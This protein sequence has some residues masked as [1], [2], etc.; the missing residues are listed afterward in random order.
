M[1][2]DHGHKIKTEFYNSILLD[3]RYIL[4][5]SGSGPNSIRFWEALGAGAIPVLLADTL[6]LP[7]HELWEKSIVRIKECELE[8]IDDILGEINEEEER[9][10]RENCLKLYEYFR[11]NYKNII[12]D[13]IALDIHVNYI[14][15]YYNVFGH[16]Y[17]DHLFILYKIKCWLEETKNIKIK[18]IYVPNQ[19]K[20]AS[21]IIPFYEMLFEKVLV[22]PVDNM[23]QL[24]TIIGSI[25]GTETN[26]IY[27]DRSEIPFNIPNDVMTNGRKLTDLNRKR[28]KELREIIWKHCD[29]QT[30]DRKSSKEILIVDRKQSPRKLINISKLLE[31]LD[32]K[33]YKTRFILME[34]FTLKEQIRLSYSYDNILMPSGS[35]YTHMAFMNENSNYYELCAPGWRYPNPLIF[36]NIYNINVKLFMLPLKNVM[37]HYRNF[38]NYT[39][40]LYQHIDS[41]PSISTNSKEDISRECNLY[42]LLLSPNCIKCFDMRGILDV[43]CIDHLVQLKKLL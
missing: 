2:E 37:P 32:S 36:G 30:V 6:E 12:Q 35:G 17:L 38:N 42:N 4:A 20:L 31:L 10:R 39:K 15:S 19:D 40:Q 9:E 22:K 18:N 13:T 7:K 23:I 28:A 26:K 8:N 14:G 11:N 25:K 41:A 24:G 29:I 33:N 1:N 27:L 5:P 43:D 21:F 34:N 16:F 3:S